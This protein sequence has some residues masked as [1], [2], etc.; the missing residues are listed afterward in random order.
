MG[1]MR[2]EKKNCAHH[3]EN[4]VLWTWTLVFLSICPDGILVSLIKVIKVNMTKYH[5]QGS[6]CDTKLY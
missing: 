6:I 1:L 4:E 3:K 2:I 5:I